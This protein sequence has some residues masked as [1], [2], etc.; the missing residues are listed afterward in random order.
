MSRMSVREIVG[1]LHILYGADVPL[2][3]I[4]AVSDA[5]LDEIGA[6]RTAHRGNG[7]KYSIA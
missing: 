1:R 3:P 4:I 6:W 2:D 5:V 7:M